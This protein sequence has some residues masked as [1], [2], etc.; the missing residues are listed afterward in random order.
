MVT[1]PS[2]SETRGAEE[3]GISSQ[4]VLALANDQQNGQTKCRCRDHTA[5]NQRALEVRPTSTEQF[6]LRLLPDGSWL[7]SHQVLQRGLD[8]AS[9]GQV[10]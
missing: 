9:T 1:T 4:L 8:V 3:R 7:E 5:E 6:D 2:G 10:Y